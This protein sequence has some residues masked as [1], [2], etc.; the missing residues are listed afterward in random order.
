[1]VFI[2]YGI[3]TVHQKTIVEEYNYFIDRSNEIKVNFITQRDIFYE[4]EGY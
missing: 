1:M 3:E 4:T 2:K